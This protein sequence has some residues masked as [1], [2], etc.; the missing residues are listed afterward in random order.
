MRNL[1][2]LLSSV[3]VIEHCIFLHA[4]KYKILEIFVVLNENC[5]DVKD[6]IEHYLRPW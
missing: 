2:Y 1:I 4:M 5:L 3:Y 6:C